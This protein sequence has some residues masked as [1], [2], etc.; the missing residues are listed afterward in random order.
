MWLYDLFVLPADTSP[1]TIVSP[2]RVEDTVPV[3]VSGDYSFGSDGVSVSVEV[4]GEGW[5]S[6]LKVVDVAGVSGEVKRVEELQ[7]M[8]LKVERGRYGLRGGIL[9]EDLM[10]GRVRGEGVEAYGKGASLLYLRRYAP[11]IRREVVLTGNYPG[12]YT[13][14]DRP[15]V[16]RS[17]RVYM[18]GRPLKEGDYRLAPEG[19]ALYLFVPF[20][21]GDL[22]TVEYQPASLSPS[23]VLTARVGTERVGLSLY[24]ERPAV[25]VLNG[26]VLTGN[27]DY[28]LRGDTFLLV[29]GKGN[30]SCTFVP[31]EGGEYSFTGSEYIRTGSGGY[32]LVPP[33]TSPR[34][35]L[36]AIT[37]SGG[38]GR[39]RLVGGRVGDTT[40]YGAVWEARTGSR[41]YLSTSGDLFRGPRPTVG[42][43]NRSLWEGNKYGEAR[44]GMGYDGGGVSLF[45]Q[46]VSGVGERTEV[47][48]RGEGR[49]RMLFG[50]YS[51]FPVQRRGKV[52]VRIREFEAHYHFHWD[53]ATAYRGVGLE[54][55]GV[56]AN[57][58]RYGDGFL[59]YSLS[60][61]VRRVSLHYSL[62]PLGRS[63]MGS[64]GARWRG[65]SVR[66][67]V[68]SSQEF[69]RQ[70]RF[71]Y[72][73]KGWGDYERDS[74][75]RFVPYPYG[76]YRKE[77][78]YF[79]KGEPDYDLSLYVSGGKFGVGL[80]AK[81]GRRVERYDLNAHSVGEAYSVRGRVSEDRVSTY[82]S[83]E[84]SAEARIGRRWYLSVEAVDRVFGSDSVLYASSEVGYSR[85]WVEGGMEVMRGRAYALS[86]VVRTRGWLTLE[87]GYRVFF[88]EAGPEVRYKSPGPFLRVTLRAGRD[89]EGVRIEGSLT[90]GYDLLRTWYYTF[91]FNVAGSL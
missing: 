56:G 4:L 15:V 72:V 70:E 75:G 10:T 12:P 20:N 52:G 21:D 40:A 46:V 90:G 49:Y 47:G 23:H 85:G 44:V 60:L 91:A 42:R 9:T 84:R 57:V 78:I 76:S 82:L 58:R 71:V 30:L 2:V 39:V 11:A 54:S 6:R 29:P 67:N 5:R 1:D 19:N 35:T 81:V 45:G 69:Y 37:L 43:Y 50:E 33:D 31:S 79:P 61:K 41:L 28:V 8:S 83:S 51:L 25:R 77:V 86:P 24:H 34:T 89:V 53:T 74:A 27:G 3:R 73:G 80:S 55:N 48:Y 64:A 17:V 13:F 87:G 14:S 16:R 66:G 26:C 59:G 32:R 22:L 63:L 36:G 62:T 18:N 65:I 68:R 88:G 38:S 7:E